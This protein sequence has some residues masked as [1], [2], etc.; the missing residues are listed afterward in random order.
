MITAVNMNLCFLTLYVITGVNMNLRY[1]VI[2]ESV[3]MVRLLETDASKRCNLDTTDEYEL[4]VERAGI[5]LRHP[6]SQTDICC[7]PFTY[8]VCQD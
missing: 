1:R 3:F 8:V 4:H 7:W 2:L 5:K 6:M